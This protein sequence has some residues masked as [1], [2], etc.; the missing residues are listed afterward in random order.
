MFICS[1]HRNKTVLEHFHPLNTPLQVLSIE[2]GRT[3]LLQGISQGKSKGA[4][5]PAQRKLYV[6]TL[7][8]EYDRAVSVTFVQCLCILCLLYL[9]K[10]VFRVFSGLFCCGKIYYF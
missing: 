4:A 5:L 10:I 6:G 3:V 7:A 1:S 2:K 9:I 8:P